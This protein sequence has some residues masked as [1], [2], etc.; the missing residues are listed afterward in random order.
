VEKDGGLTAKQMELAIPK[1]RKR[2][3]EL[4]EADVNTVQGLE[5]TKLS[6]LWQKLDSALIDIF[7]VDTDMYHKHYVKAF[8]MRVM[9][10]PKG[11]PLHEIRENYAKDIDQAIWQLQTLIEI[12]EERLDDH[13]DTPASKAL[14]ALGDLEIHPEIEQA[15]SQLFRDGHYAESVAAACKVLDQL[16]KDL[17]KIT[18]LSGNKL[19]E[20]AFG[21]EKPILKFNDLETP[22]DKS[23]QQGMMFLYKG[24][25]LAIRNPRAHEIIEDDPAT[26]LEYIGFLSFLAKASSRT[27]RE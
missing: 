19:M 26:A 13:K 5:D 14:K 27:K 11:Q 22:T 20:K 7:G 4:K 8:G 10:S 15:S 21:S 16:V 12:F 24:A 18:N 17:S 6:S 23:E 2:I 1:L 9:F 3:A 25:M